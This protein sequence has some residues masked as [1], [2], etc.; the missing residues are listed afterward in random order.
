MKAK[1]TYKVVS[2]TMVCEEKR[3]VCYGIA[4]E[5]HAIHHISTDWEMVEMIADIANLLDLDPDRICDV[6]EEILP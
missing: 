1:E 2:E 4:S 6:I 3:Y 5:K